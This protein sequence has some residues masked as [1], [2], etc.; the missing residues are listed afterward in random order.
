M[1]NKSSNF[2]S[3]LEATS[4]LV[5]TIIGAGI[6]GI[7]YVVVKAGFWTGLLVMIIIAIAMV[8]I[9]LLVSEIVLSTKDNHQLTGYAEKYLGIKGKYIMFFTIIFSFYGAL[10]SY[11]IGGGQVLAALFN[12]NQ[13]IFSLLFF[14]VAALL[15]YLGLTIIKKFEFL[16]TLFIL[17]I[18]IVIILTTF[19]SLNFS[20]LT[21]FN[22]HNLF[23]PYGVIFFALGGSSALPQLRRVLINKE[24][25]IKRSIIMGI[26]IPF[27]VYL[28]FTIIVIGI[29]GFNTTEV[30]TIGLGKALGPAMIIFANLFAF[31]CIGTSF[32]T[33]GLALKETYIYDIKLKHSLAWFLT[34][35]IPLTLFLL[36]LNSFVKVLGWAGA[37]GGGIEGL[38]ILAIFLKLKSLKRTERV[39]EYKIPLHWPII[40][41]IGLIFIGGIIYTLLNFL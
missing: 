23:I 1:E 19:K 7:P 27:L 11:I 32:L 15:I 10:L 39:P 9:K 37:L 24:H 30:A 22:W 5:G 3:S 38:L 16:M 33:L 21:G 28:I 14:A 4:I 20:N 25:L 18:I 34:C 36:G 12:G 13:F 29:N 17:I 35:L 40:I 2:I 8:I 41:F 6:F 31:F 26:A